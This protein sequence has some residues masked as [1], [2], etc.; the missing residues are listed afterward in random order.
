MG[1]VGFGLAA[2]VRCH[3]NGCA[4]GGL[5]CAVA[6]MFIPALTPATMSTTIRESVGLERRF[7]WTATP[8]FLYKESPSNRASPKPRVFPRDRDL[9][10]QSI[11]A[12]TWHPSEYGSGSRQ[13]CKGR[14]MDVRRGWWW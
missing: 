1:R 8:L 11:S 12:K 7:L 2:Q 4:G 14:S 6:E 3:N 13:Y 5:I 10:K 9:S